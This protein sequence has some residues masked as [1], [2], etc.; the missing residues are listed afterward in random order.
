MSDMDQIRDNSM[1]ESRLAERLNETLVR[2][3]RATFILRLPAS[4]A[5][6]SRAAA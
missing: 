3:E 6:G 1:K 2:I 5:E 4:A